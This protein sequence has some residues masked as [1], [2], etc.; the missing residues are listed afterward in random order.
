[1]DSDKKK[2]QYLLIGL[3][4]AL[5][6]ATVLLFLRNHLMVN[7]MN[8]IEDR[9]K[10]FNAQLEG[11]NYIQPVD[12]ATDP[13]QGLATAI[14]K[15]YV[16]SSFSCSHCAEYSLVLNKLASEQGD[17]VEII[18]KDAV[19]VDDLPGQNAAL[20]ARCAQ[21]QNK[22]W[23]YHGLLFTNQNKL[24]LTDFINYAQQLSLNMTDFTSCLTK[25]K[26]ATLVN[27]DY[28]EA[29]AVGIDGT[30][31]SVFNNKRLS[32]LQTYDFLVSLI[33]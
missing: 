5:L 24:T 6:L 28:N 4:L 21:L 9:A 12:L 31:F 14:N 3:F 2:Q 17:K 25:Q 26:T 11:I 33:K 18:W 29:L 23:Q 1:M 32:G 30:P 20:A 22:F 10:Q 8:S 19:A 15:L 27:Q 16:Y 13:R 7:E